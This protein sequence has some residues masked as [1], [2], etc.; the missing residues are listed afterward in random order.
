MLPYK[1]GILAN[2]VL[3]LKN[4]KEWS[5]SFLPTTTAKKKKKN[6]TLIVLKVL[7][8]LL[9][10]PPP[11][12]QV[13]I[14]SASNGALMEQHQRSSTALGFLQ[15]NYPLHK[16]SQHSLKCFQNIPTKGELLKMPRK[17]HQK[18]SGTDL[19]KSSG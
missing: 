6:L 17:Q 10:L 4:L 14:Q 5:P 2:A 16:P 1:L 7:L 11:C 19:T 12:S 8:D 3:D 13:Q 15:V 9:L 18:E